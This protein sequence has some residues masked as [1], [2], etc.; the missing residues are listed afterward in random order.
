MAATMATDLDP[1]PTALSRGSTHARLA[2][3]T[4]MVMKQPETD[5][6]DVGC[7]R[8]VVINRSTTPETGA[9]AAT[10]AEAMTVTMTVAFAVVPSVLAPIKSPCS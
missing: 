3:S 8:E 4:L 9:V 10:V 2:L 6:Q 1:H 5:A 7:S